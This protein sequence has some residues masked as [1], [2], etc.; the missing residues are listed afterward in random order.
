VRSC[1]RHGDRDRGSELDQ[2]SERGSFGGSLCA[3]SGH[4]L[5]TTARISSE[6][7]SRRK[8]SF[9]SG[10]RFGAGRFYSSALWYPSLLGEG[11]SLEA[12]GGTP[13]NRLIWF[14]RSLS[15]AWSAAPPRPRPLAFPVAWARPLYPSC[16]FMAA[17]TLMRMTSKVGIGTEC[18]VKRNAGLSAVSNAIG[19]RS[20]FSKPTSGQ[21][22]ALGGAPPPQQ[23][24]RQLRR[25][26]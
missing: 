24:G 25:P 4:S 23:R 12:K 17:I 13:W 18:I 10:R 21:K 22:I 19:T 8:R 15:S 5:S 6:M 2:L 3:S 26:S 9:S 7:W 11:T 16:R 1:V 20:R 14:L